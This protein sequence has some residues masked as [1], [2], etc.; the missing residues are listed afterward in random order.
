MDGF[1]CLGDMLGVGGDAGVAVEAR[2][3]VGWSAF[4]W[5]VLLLA[6]G[7]MSLILEGRLCGDCVRGGVVRGGGTWPRV[8]LLRV[9]MG[10]VGCI[11]VVW[12]QDGVQGGGW[13]RDWGWLTCS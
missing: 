1:C 8:A 5:L 3:R 10:V 6:K 4:R 2:V 9:G 13:Q 11:C 12:L 7:D